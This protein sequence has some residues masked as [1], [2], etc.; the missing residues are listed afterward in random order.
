MW[1]KKKVVGIVIRLIILFIIFYTLPILNAWRKEGV[2]DIDLSALKLQQVENE[3]GSVAYNGSMIVPH[4]GYIYYLKDFRQQRG[5]YRM[6][7]EG[8]QHTKISDDYVYSMCIVKNEIYFLSLYKGLAKMNLDGSNYKVLDEEASNNMVVLGDWIYYLTSISIESQGVEEEP[9]KTILTPS[10]YAT[11][12]Y[13]IKK[14]GSMKTRV[15]DIYCREFV[16]DGEWIYCVE[17]TPK[18]LFFVDVEEIEEGGT[19]EKLFALKVDGTDMHDLGVKTSRGIAA[20]KGWLYFFK[21]KEGLFKLKLLDNDIEIVKVTSQSG[22]NIKTSP[23]YIYFTQNKKVLGGLLGRKYKSTLFRVQDDGENLIR[24]CKDDII[25]NFDII[26]EE[27]FYSTVK[28]VKPFTIYKAMV[29]NSNNRKKQL[30][31]LE[32]KNWV[33]N[34]LNKQ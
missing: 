31:F 15:G 19:P 4:K 14:D 16:I 9:L 5:I 1:E 8:N 32:F 2:H 27:V 33:F 12:I 21:E 25:V 10:T 23:N 26:G 7:I 29:L 17:D 3:N 18:E 13:K 6:D 11:C 24:M 22:N 28:F 20:N 30:F 34:Y